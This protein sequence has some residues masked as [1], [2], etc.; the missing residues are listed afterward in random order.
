MDTNFTNQNQ[1]NAGQEIEKPTQK[2][3]YHAPQFRHFGNLTE[4]TQLAPLRGGDGCT[5]WVDCTF[6]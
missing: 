4:L 1:A 6:T 3:A 5:T 2:K